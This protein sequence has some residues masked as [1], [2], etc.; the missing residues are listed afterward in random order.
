MGGNGSAPRA[1]Y[2]LDTDEPMATTQPSAD[3]PITNQPL[4]F[5][6][7]L[8]PS[9]H[10][11][12]IKV[13][14]AEI[15]YVLDYFV[16]FPNRNNTTPTPAAQVSQTASVAAADVGDN[17]VA[18]LHPAVIALI[19]VV[20]LIVLSIVSCGLVFWFCR[21]KRNALLHRE[22]HKPWDSLSTDSEQDRP[23]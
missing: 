3:R 5:S 8:G 12:Q 10:S 23:G 16:V 14:E 4:F 9:E 19:A 6:R 22:S 13:E 11:L 1:S 15:P 20:G 17:P 21:R 7:G 2:T 18:P